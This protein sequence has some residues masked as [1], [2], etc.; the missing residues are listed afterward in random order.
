M[1]S[2]LC[3]VIHLLVIVISC[4]VKKNQQEK[5]KN[6]QCYNESSSKSLYSS[7]KSATGILH[8]IIGEYSHFYVLKWFC[9]CLISHQ[10]SFSLRQ[11]CFPMQARFHSTQI[12]IVSFSKGNQLPDNSENSYFKCVNILFQNY[13][14]SHFSASQTN[15][16]KLHNFVYSTKWA[17][18]NNS[19]NTLQ[20]N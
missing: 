7:A 6:A 11:H 20:N 18:T 12:N 5:K 1:S 19:S 9:L 15:W 14:T 17:T 4:L 16:D 10:F 2:I 3:D 8:T 13:L